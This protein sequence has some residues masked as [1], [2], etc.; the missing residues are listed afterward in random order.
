[1][2]ELLLKLLAI[3]LTS[4]WWLPL[5]RLVVHEAWRVAD[6]DAQRG[7]EPFRIPGSVQRASEGWRAADAESR[8]PR[9]SSWDIGRRPVQRR[10]P[11]FADN[12]RSRHAL[13]SFG[14]KRAQR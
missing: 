3:L 7:P 9:N 4:Y 6:L 14:T 8:N 1:M 2:N 12:S 10:E 11:K 5:M 13:T